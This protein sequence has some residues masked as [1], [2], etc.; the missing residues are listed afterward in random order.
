MYCVRSCS[1]NRPYFGE[2]DAPAQV[3]QLLGDNFGVMDEPVNQPDHAEGI[4]EHL[5]P[6][7][8]KALVIVSAKVGLR[9]EAQRSPR[10]RS[11]PPFMKG[12]LGGI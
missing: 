11:V 7:G 9:Y 5:I 10:N 6:F 2:Y 3:V 8:E 12:G 4:E 1:N